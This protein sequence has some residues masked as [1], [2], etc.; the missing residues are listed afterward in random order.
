M[1]AF[2]RTKLWKRGMGI[3]LAAA[4]VLGGVATPLA[5][6]HNVLIA[7]A[8]AT[9]NSMDYYS[10]NDGPVLT[11]SGV[12][13]ASYGFVMPIFNGGAASWEDVSADL[14]VRV[15]VNGSYTDIDSVSSFVYNQNW[16]HW[17]DGGFTGYWFKVSETTY[18]QLYSKTT[19]VALDY[20]LEFTN[21][22][23]TTIT[24]M[25]ATDGPVLTAG[26]TGSIGFTYPTFNG[27]SSI[28]YAAVAADLKVYVK[29]VNSSEWIDIDNNAASGW[30]YDNNFGQ[31]TDGPGGYWFVLTESIN[32]KLESKSS[33]ASLIYTLNYE[34]GA[35]KS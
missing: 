11:G 35:R 34:K 28:P 16:G 4:M 6:G 3:L 8:A 13:E 19:G 9:I 21:I 27:D 7:N 10:T 25:T 24:S 32:V 2:Q 20:T 29:T 30:I 15:K 31:F 5:G 14:A 1:K 26:P 33:G 22:N 12:G 17:N 18:L 23:T